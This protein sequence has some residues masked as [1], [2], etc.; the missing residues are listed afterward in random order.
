MPIL[1]SSDRGLEASLLSVT[2]DSATLRIAVRRVESLASCRFVYRSSLAFH[3]Q[4]LPAPF[5]DPR[6]SFPDRRTLVLPSL[7]ENSTYEFHVVCWDR[8]GREVRSNQ[9]TFTTRE[10]LLLDP[11]RSASILP[12]PPNVSD[13]PFLRIFTSSRLTEGKFIKRPR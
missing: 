1:E 6:S 12:D 2:A 10:S 11:P 5:F 4:A 9:L 8:R 7:G 13:F 3:R